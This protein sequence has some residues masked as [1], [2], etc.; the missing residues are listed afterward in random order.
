MQWH[1]DEWNK[2]AAA[3]LLRPEQ[4]ELFVY[5]FPKLIC[6]PKLRLSAP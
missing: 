6:T 4:I 1:L 2:K 3:V 5:F